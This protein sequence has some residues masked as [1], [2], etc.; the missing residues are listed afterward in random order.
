VIVVQRGAHALG[1]VG[2]GRLELA[3]KDL[4]QTVARTPGTSGS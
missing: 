3:L 4:G 2:D 1:K